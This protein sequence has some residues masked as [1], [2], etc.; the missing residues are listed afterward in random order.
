MPKYAA[1]S[2][3]IINTGDVFT[4]ISAEQPTSGT[5]SVAVCLGPEVG[6]V[7]SCSVSG[8][9]AGAPGAFEI[10]VQQ[11]DTDTDASYV[12]VPVGAVINSVN[13]NQSF[14]ASFSPIAARFVRLLTKTQN[15]NAVNCTAT[16][17]RQ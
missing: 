1:N 10:D 17:T 15:A 12:N 4:A 9:F 16:I 8:T 7:A 13:A 5:A 6:K 3:T 2:A 14:V 11:A